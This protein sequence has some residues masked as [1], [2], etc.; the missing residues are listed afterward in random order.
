MKNSSFKAEY[1]KVLEKSFVISV[2]IIALLFYFFPMFDV[3]IELKAHLPDI[4]LN[5]DTP[6]TRQPEKR[7]RPALPKIPVANEEEEMLEAVEIDFLE[8]RE[9]W[10]VE[11][12][13]IPDAEPTETYEFFAVS[14]KP[15]LKQKVSPVYPVLARK[16]G[17]EGMVV[18]K[19]LIDTKGDVIEAMVVK[20]IPMLDS[21]ALDAAKMFKFTPGKQRDRIV[22]V[23]M[24]IP[25]KFNLR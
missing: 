17:V 21:A 1:Q 10:F 25:F 9:N 6:P 13:E 3:G 16:A 4:I 24:Q 11:N 20:S 2:M 22:R 19:V 5:L 14:D 7:V 15:V 23:W 8:M 18:V 12:P